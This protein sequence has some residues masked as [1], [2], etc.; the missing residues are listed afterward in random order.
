MNTKQAVNLLITGNVIS[1]S[2]QMRPH[3]E[4]ALSTQ[5][6]LLDRVDQTKFK[7]TKIAHC[8]SCGWYVRLTDGKLQDHGSPQCDG[9][10]GV[11]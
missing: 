4:N 11:P 8:A 6:Y 9:S 2:P 3:V 10:G 5:L 7:A 1:L